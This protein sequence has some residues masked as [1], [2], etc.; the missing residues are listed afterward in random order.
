VERPVSAVPLPM[1]LTV[2]L[3]AVL[4]M[5]RKGRAEVCQK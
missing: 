3:I 5:V 4:P 2:F 1:A